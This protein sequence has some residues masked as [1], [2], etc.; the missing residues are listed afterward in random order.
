M[1]NREAVSGGSRVIQDSCT[2]C[3]SEQP[4]S[5][6]ALSS[7]FVKWIVGFYKLIFTSLS[8]SFTI[9][10]FCSGY[11]ILVWIIDF[12]TWC[13]LYCIFHVNQTTEYPLISILSRL[14]KWR[15]TLRVQF[16]Y[17]IQILSRSSDFIEEEVKYPISTNIKWKRRLFMLVLNISMCFQNINK[18][19]NSNRWSQFKK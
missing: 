15:S 2:S 8:D 10:F 12:C 11:F 19:A 13:I 16:F 4:S 18:I 7:C 1:N 14:S 5:V 6:Q 9:Y 3:L 17:Q